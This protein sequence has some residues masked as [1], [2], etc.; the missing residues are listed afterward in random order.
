M[1]PALNPWIVAG[2]AILGTCLVLAGHTMLP[3]YDWRPVGDGHAVVVYD[4]WS[5]RFQRTE[6]DAAGKPH[7]SDVYTAP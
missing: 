5:G 2:A 3:R 7:L 1:H 6:W 4:R